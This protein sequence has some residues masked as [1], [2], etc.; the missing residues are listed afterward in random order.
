MQ[1]VE[2]AKGM[3]EE[4]H[5]ND[6][7]WFRFS[8]YEASSI[9]KSMGLAEHPGLDGLKMAL[10]FRVDTGIN[11]QSLVD[12]PADSFI[13]RMDEAGSR[14]PG[15]AKLWLMIL[16]VRRTGKIYLFHPGC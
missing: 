1:R 3:N 10:G 5:C 11:R 8:P 13:F 9:K 7:L 16:Q 14:Q 12:E 4:K 6:S 2:F 15:N